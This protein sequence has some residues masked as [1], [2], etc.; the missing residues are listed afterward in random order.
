MTIGTSTPG[1]R[2][3]TYFPVC[4]ARY[5]PVGA[6]IKAQVLCGAASTSA[7]GDRVVPPERAPMFWPLPDTT[8]LPCVLYRFIY[9]LCTCFLRGSCFVTIDRGAKDRISGASATRERKGA[10]ALFPAFDC[11]TE[12]GKDAQNAGKEASTVCGILRCDEC[13]DLSDD[14]RGFYAVEN[15][16]VLWC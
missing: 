1:N 3:Q 9:C 11:N 15:R 5:K 8:L 6:Q 2:E 4:V 16:K 14:S 10:L 13:F 12:K 7:C